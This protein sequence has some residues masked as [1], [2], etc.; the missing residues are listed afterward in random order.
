MPFRDEEWEELQRDCDTF[1]AYSDYL[2]GPDRRLVVTQEPGLHPLI[3]PTPTPQ[4]A[5]NSN[6]M[7]INSSDPRRRLR[8]MAEKEDSRPK[9]MSRQH[10]YA[11]VP[12]TLRRDAYSTPIGVTQQQYHTHNYATPAQHILCHQP[13]AFTLPP[14]IQI[15]S[16]Y[17]FPIIF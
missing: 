17:L 11:Y 4:P 5:Q 15:V 9:A 7:P 12:S 8:T 10:G 3:Y 2:F 6:G 13:S 1:P 16:L 14:P